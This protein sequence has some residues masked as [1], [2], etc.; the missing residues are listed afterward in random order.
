MYKI[1]G[2]IS[3]LSSEQYNI[4]DDPS[5]KLQLFAHSFEH[6]NS[7][8]HTSA[9]THVHI[10]KLKLSKGKKRKRNENKH[11][12]TLRDNDDDEYDD[13]GKT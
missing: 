11:K 4:K 9:H 7:Q 3:F 2:Q 13:Y 5:Y 12:T 6:K 1:L 10:F 8:I